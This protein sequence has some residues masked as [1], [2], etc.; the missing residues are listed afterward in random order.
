MSKIFFCFDLPDG[1]FS[2]SNERSIYFRDWTQYTWRE[3]IESGRATWADFL[4][5]RLEMMD[6]ETMERAGLDTRMSTCTVACKFD[7][8][9]K[10]EYYQAYIST[11]DE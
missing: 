10:Q 1:F 8:E 6:T 9:F 2:K 3:E 11:G 5:Y 7:V 4:R